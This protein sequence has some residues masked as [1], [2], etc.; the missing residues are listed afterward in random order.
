MY[1]TKR[2]FLFFWQGKHSGVLLPLVALI[3]LALFLEGPLVLVWPLD[4][5]TK[6][7][8]PDLAGIVGTLVSTDCSSDSGDSGDSDLTVSEEFV[9]AFDIVSER[10]T[11]LLTFCAFTRDLK[12]AGILTVLKLLEAPAGLASRLVF[13]GVIY[14]GP[15][16]K[17]EIKSEHHK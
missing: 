4:L 17:F 8:S 11:G 7:V 13:K 6:L 2:A 9:G 1:L 10:T 16:K 12:R 14:H 5:A 15:R 3:P